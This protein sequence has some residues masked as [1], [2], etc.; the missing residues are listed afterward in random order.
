MLQDKMFH[1]IGGTSG[2]SDGAK[3]LRAVVKKL[4]SP[5]FM[6]AI[7]WTGKSTAGKGSKISFQ[8]YKNII[9]M[10]SNV[11]IAADR[12]LNEQMVIQDLKYRVIKYAYARPKTPSASS[13]TVESTTTTVTTSC[14]PIIEVATI[15]S[16]DSSSDEARCE[17]IQPQQNT[18][19][20]IADQQQMYQQQAY[21]QQ[22]AYQPPPTYHQQHTYY[23]QRTPHQQHP[24]TMY[25]QSNYPTIPDPASH[26][27]SWLFPSNM[28]YT[29]L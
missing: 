3:V 21:Q 24:S 19:G 11:C 1:K 9:Q 28:T 20:N 16:E 6:S 12:K 15:R 4:I 5:D 8:I 25:S 23:Q 26:H 10:I 18:F 13:D 14:D 2:G 27:D 29:S 22:P 7:S 17:Q